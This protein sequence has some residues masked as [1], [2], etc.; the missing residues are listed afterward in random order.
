MFVLLLSAVLAADDGAAA[1]APT[2]EQVKFFETSVR[3][4]LVEHCHK[5]H[6]EKKQWASLRLDSR[7]AVLRGGDSGPA[8][9]PGKPAESLLIRAVKHEEDV[10]PMPEDGKLTERQ[11]ADLVQ[12]VEMGAPYPEAPA[13]AARTGDKNHWAFHP[14]V[15]Q[16]LPAVK[17]AAWP[18]S[19]VDPF[20]LA[21]IEAAG[22]APAELADKRTLVGR[23]TFDLT[24]LPPTPEEVDQFVADEQP[25]ALARLVDRLLA[26]PAYGERWGR[27]W[28]DVARYADSNGLDENVAHGNAFRYRDYVVAAFNAD[29]PLDRFVVEQLAGD[30]LPAES[31]PQRHEQLIATGFLTIG[32]KVLAE[33]DE[34][35][36]QMDIVDEQIDAVGRVFIGLTLGCARCHDHKFDPILAA[37]YYGL[38]GIFKSTRAMESYKKVAKWHENPLPSREAH[39]LQAEYDAQVKAQQQAIDALVAKAD[40]EVRKEKA[41]AALP[42]KLEPLYS[43]ANKAELK[44]M[45]EE[46]TTLQKNPPELPSAMGVA[47]DQV[48]DV[49]IHIRGNPLKL[50]DVVERHTPPVMRGPAPPQFGPSTSGRLELAQW[51]VDAQHPL[52]SRVIV[53]R[54]WRWRF[55]HGIVRSTDNF[56]LLGEPPSHPELL[57]WLS[58]RLVADGWSL[59]RLHRLL[60][61]SSTYQQ[62]SETAAERLAADPENRLFSRASVRRLEAE[63]VRDSLLSVS[64]QLDRTLGGSLL[65][66]KNRGYFF[67]HTSIDLT[68]YNSRRRSLYLPVVRNNVYDLFQLLD[69][70]DPAIPSGDRATTTVAPQ[71]LLMLNSDLVMQSA[72]ELAGR[73][74]AESVDDEQR[75]ARLYAI[76]YGREATAEERQANRAFLAEVDQSLA[77]KEPDADKRR[78]QAWAVLCHTVI[79][80]SEFIYVR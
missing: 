17:N 57:D 42:D 25:D 61:A 44:K 37:D 48:M 63:E 38:A 29:K 10:S 35:K 3:P 77:A 59:K 16:P 23:V 27:H 51:L 32:P 76:A 28:L 15:P 55:G 54:V 67:D 62:A 75:L 31:E 21:R 65:K 19:A 7:A 20:V 40:E 13:T 46:L 22:L 4:V 50:G 78:R 68:D 30:L 6:G 64:G 41:G 70:P 5:C 18:Q 36:M 60:L 43:D 71:A 49:A 79:A 45:R 2:A 26:S 39:A 52:T 47:E 24:G 12:W 69:F 33:V 58:Q 53:N 9:V 72:D 8:V 66:V 14:P 74:L 11:I 56:G 34:A 1:Q 73:L 80:A